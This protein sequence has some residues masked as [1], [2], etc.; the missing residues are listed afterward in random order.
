MGNVPDGSAS[1]GGCETC[2]RVCEE[3]K[4]RSSQLEKKNFR[5][6]IALTSALTL[7]GEQGVKAVVGM[8]ES[9]RSVT[10][11]AEKPPTTAARDTGGRD[12]SFGRGGNGT[13]SFSR[14]R[15]SWTGT[16]DDM[17]GDDI[18][19]PPQG[20]GGPSGTLLSGSSSMS[21]AIVA[22]AVLPPSADPLAPILPASV[23]LASMPSY[24]DGIATDVHD[25]TTPSPFG[26]YQAHLE[27][28]PTSVSTVPSPGTLCVF[29]V[30]GMIGSRSRA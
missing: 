15:P 2:A 27:T 22:S 8:V 11:V 7:L 3:A 20:W 10:E 12:Y 18:W 14:W 16:A 6:A 13:P 1:H 21:S 23:V 29:A 17:S 9:M 26:G 30:G 28:A 25:F 4:Q 19:L 24:L 5:L